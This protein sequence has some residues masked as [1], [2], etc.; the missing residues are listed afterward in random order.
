M[1]TPHLGPNGCMRANSDLL[2]GPSQPRSR[3][4]HQPTTQQ[5]KA[6]ARGLIVPRLLT[7]PD[8]MGARTALCRGLAVTGGSATA[9]RFA[10]SIACRCGSPPSICAGCSPSA[11]DATTPA[12]RSPSQV[13][14]GPG[15]QARTSHLATAIQRGRLAPRTPALRI[16]HLPGPPEQCMT[17]PTSLKPPC[18]AGS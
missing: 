18:S 3:P 14:A 11:Y 7:G 16:G 13:V 6:P 8:P 2:S 17:H 12:G 5:P 1:R 4:D 10:T 15:C 9:A